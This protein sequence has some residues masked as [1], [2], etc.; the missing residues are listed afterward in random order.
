FGGGSVTTTAAREMLGTI[1]RERV[2]AILDAL[3]TGD[4]RRVIDAAHALEE[5]APDY[6]AVLDELAGVLV[7]VALRQA[8]PDYD[9][10]EL[11]D[12]ALVERL[13][14]TVPAEDVQL[15]YQTAII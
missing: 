5:W 2:A 6:G 1:D 11:P 15:Y 8:V 13:A 4:A 3:A 14:A 12:A 9:L 7:Q 10:S